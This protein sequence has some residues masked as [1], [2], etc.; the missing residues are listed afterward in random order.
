VS[1]LTGLREVLAARVFVTGL[2]TDVTITPQSTAASADGGFTPGSTSNGTATTIKGIPYSNTT[3][4][5]FREMFGNAKLGEGAC[6]VPHNTSI[7]TGDKI[8]WLSKTYHVESV[9]D[10]PI[11]NGVAVKLILGNERN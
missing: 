5:L 4:K 7:N 9:E 2:G 1:R 8:A 10:I 11:D 3:Q 6:L